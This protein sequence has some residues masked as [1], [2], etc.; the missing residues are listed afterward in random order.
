MM[1]SLEICKFGSLHSVCDDDEIRMLEFS[2][3]CVVMISLE[4][5]K[6]GRLHGVCC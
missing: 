1:I 6:S 5:R 4:V 2:T 3:L